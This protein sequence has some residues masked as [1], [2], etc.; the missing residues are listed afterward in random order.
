MVAWYPDYVPPQ[1]LPAGMRSA[2][3]TIVENQSCSDA[4]KDAFDRDVQLCTY[5]PAKSGCQGDSGGPLF[6]KIKGRFVQVGIV[7]WGEGCA[8]PG[9]PGV[10]TRLSNPSIQGFIRSVMSQK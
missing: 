2:E 9:W 7:S 4:Y 6:R 5:E 3:L 8:A 10:F 1:V